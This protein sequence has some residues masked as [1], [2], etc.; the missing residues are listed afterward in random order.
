MFSSVS[1]YKTALVTAGLKVELADD[2][3][4]TWKEFVKSRHL[5]FA[6]DEAKLTGLYGALSRLQ[7]RKSGGGCGGGA[8]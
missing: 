3:T 8:R 5:Q 6:K 4:P 2:V 7:H 1:A